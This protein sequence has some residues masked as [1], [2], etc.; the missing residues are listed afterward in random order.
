MDELL[1]A[2]GTATLMA[3]FVD[4]G[5]MLAGYYAC[6][7]CPNPAQRGTQAELANFVRFQFSLFVDF[8]YLIW[9]DAS[10]ASL[11]ANSLLLATPL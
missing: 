1:V 7:A 5:N 6:S 11:F 8:L 10:F 2:L 4:L 3:F 9:L